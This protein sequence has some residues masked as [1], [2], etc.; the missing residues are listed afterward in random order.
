[1][2]WIG[3]SLRS[4]VGTLL[5]VFA[6]VLLFRHVW[7]QVWI[8]GVAAG[9][10]CALVAGERSG[11]RGITVGTIAVWAAAAVDADARGVGV[12]HISSTLGLTRWVAYLACMGLAF[13]LGGLSISRAAKTRTPGT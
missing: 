2:N 9:I 12:L 4:L 11:L 8:V 6:G 13:F 5:G 3:L 1:M 10:G 7:P